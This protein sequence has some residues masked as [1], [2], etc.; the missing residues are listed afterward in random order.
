MSYS[1]QHVAAVVG[2]FPLL[3]CSQWKVTHTELYCLYSKVCI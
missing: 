3:E 2:V 1:I